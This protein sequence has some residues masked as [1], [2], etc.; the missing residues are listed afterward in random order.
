VIQNY[1]GAIAKVFIGLVILAALIGAGVALQSEIAKLVSKPV[2]SSFG[3]SSQTITAGQSADLQWN[4]TGASSVSISPGIGT[5]P[6]SGARTVTPDKTTT[7]KLVAGNLFGSVD[8]SAK[9]EVTGV[10]PNIGGF[11]FSPDNIVAGQPATLSW[12]VTGADSVSISP[13]IGPV[14]PTGQQSVSPGTTTRYT[15]TATNSS[16]NSTASATITVAVG[17]AP[18]ISTFSANPASI[19]SGESTTLTWDVTGSTSINIDQGIG[20]VGSKGS[21]VVRPVATTTYTLTAIGVTKAVTVAVNTTNVKS[22]AGSTIPTSAPKISSFSVSPGTITLADNTTLVWAVTG[23]RSVTISPDV[24]TVSPSGSILI[25]PR[26]TTTY[27]LTA[28]NNYGTENATAV[29]TVS[30][31]T[32]HTAPVIR[33]FTATPSSVPAGGTSKLTWSI[34]GATAVSIDNGIGIPASY[35]SEEVSPA[36]TTT[37]TLT[38]FNSSGST[39]ATVTL[40]VEP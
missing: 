6:S 8:Q 16:G 1:K 4:V 32:D 38:A 17:G 31:T 15:L 19:N 5:V 20:G 7:Y 40:T 22:T 14:Q 21:T 3:A 12:N 11:G 24:G 34:E 33:S 35:Y 30:T 27:R 2:V 25:I 37:Y 9:I 18:I 39:D 10:L 13:T 26:G 36:E 28:V 23:V 29:V